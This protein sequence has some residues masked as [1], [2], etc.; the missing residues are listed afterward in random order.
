MEGIDYHEIF[1]PVVKL[2]STHIVLALVA[3][4][5]LELEQLDVKTTFLHGDLDEEIYMEQP[6]CFVHHQKGRLVC[7]LKKSLYCLK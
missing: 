5:D 7:K 1:S 2:V 3:L 6:E 4:L